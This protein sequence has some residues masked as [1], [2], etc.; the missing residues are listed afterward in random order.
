MRAAAVLFFDS[1]PTLRSD[2][3]CSDQ[4]HLLSVEVLGGSQDLTPAG[5]QVPLTLRSRRPEH[6]IYPETTWQLVSARARLML[7]ALREQRAP[8]PVEIARASS[9]AGSYRR[10]TQRR[11]K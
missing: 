1:R 7:D 8:S 9:S 6:I 3:D 11:E 10:K 5:V 2:D 4:L